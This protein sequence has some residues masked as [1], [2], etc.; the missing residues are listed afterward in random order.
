M[1][2]MER[3]IFEYVAIALLSAILLLSL[4][5]V[6]TQKT[7]EKDTVSVQGISED[8]VE[9][10]MYSVTVG[11][12]I[13]GDD[14]EEIQQR[15]VE[16][17]Q[18]LKEAINEAGVPEN[19]LKSD[20]YSIRPQRG[21]IRSEPSNEFVG[22]Q[23]LVF[24][25]ENVSYINSILGVAVTNRATVVDNIRFMLSDEKKE[26]VEEQLLGQAVK[27]ARQKASVVAKGDDRT[28]GKS[29]SLD[30]QY[31]SN[32]PYLRSQDAVRESSTPSIDA[33]FIDYS[34][35]VSAQFELQ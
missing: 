21:T 22:S 34:V 11:V 32:I 5:A 33:G 29:M 15:I 2:Y 12:T 7:V 35:S 31:S 1:Q 10:D 26:D 25:G 4:A 27:D 3:K 20:T 8:Q 16:D 24:E 28:I 30:T 13:E 17:I 23:Q 14:P 19:H 9:P 18:Q 6:V